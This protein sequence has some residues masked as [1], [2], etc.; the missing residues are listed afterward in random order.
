M[1]HLI[2]TVIIV[3]LILNGLMWNVKH[4]LSHSVCL[5]KGMNE[6]II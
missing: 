5:T 4:E 3:L 2:Y 6:E 1:K